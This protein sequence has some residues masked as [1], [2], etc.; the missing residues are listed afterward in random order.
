MLSLTAKLRPICSSEINGRNAIYA[1][2]EST[3]TWWQ[4]DE[5]DT[6]PY[7]ICDLQGK[8]TVSAVRIFWHEEGL[9]YQ[10]GIVPSAIKYVL[11]GYNGGEWFNLLDCSNNT[12]DLNIDYKTFES[13]S[14][15]KVKLTILDSPEGI[16]IGV[17]DF[18]VFGKMEE[19]P[20]KK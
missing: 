6:K 20:F 11:E 1:T 8:F 14:C 2:D 13:K 12:I 18:S 17:I 19:N 5:K 3:I 9:D 16:S 4:P 10:N 7:I 15:S